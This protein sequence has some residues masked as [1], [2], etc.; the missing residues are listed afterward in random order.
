MDTPKKTQSRTVKSAA[1]WRLLIA[2]FASSSMSLKAFC[3][4]EKVSTSAFYRWRDLLGEVAAKTGAEMK[5]ATSVPAGF[6]DAG[7]LA[8]PHALAGSMQLRLELG[9][10]IVLTLVQH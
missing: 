6:I 3:E 7:S 5:E 1:Q 2:R 4:V 10:G 9:H 8:A